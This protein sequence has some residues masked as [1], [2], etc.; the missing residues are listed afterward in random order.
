MHYIDSQEKLNT[1]IINKNHSIVVV[2]Y[3]LTHYLLL[4]VLCTANQGWL[5]ANYNPSFTCI[6]V[7]DLA[8]C[9][10]YP[11][12]IIYIVWPDGYTNIRVNF[13]HCTRYFAAYSPHNIIYL[14][15][16]KMYL[17]CSITATY[18][19]IIKTGTYCP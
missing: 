9:Y 2:C 7:T 19:A 12:L 8:F 17:L 13:Q 15:N 5:F 11:T 4:S 18:S 1:S 3:I 14:P 10:S 16:S 6:K